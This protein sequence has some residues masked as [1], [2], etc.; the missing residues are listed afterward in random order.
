MR[1]KGFGI[2]VGLVFSLQTLAQ[3]IQI[4]DKNQSPI[5]DVFIYHDKRSYTAFTDA[6]G[7]A[8]I[9][10]FPVTGYFHFQHPA[11]EL[12]HIEAESLRSQNF[13]IA[14]EEK[15]VWFNELVISASKWE[16][17]EKDLAQQVMSVDRK[18]VEFNNPAT[19][20]DM[21]SQSGQVF[22]QKSQLGG[23][24]PKIR[25]FSAN[26]V[27]L[28]VD[29]VRM[30]NAIYRGGN[31]QNIINIDPN[32]ISSSE[33]VFGPGSVIYGSDA[34][35]GV[36]DFHTVAPR[37]N[38]N[39]TDVK[40]NL[41]TRYSSAA[42]ERTFHG[43]VAVA[44]RKFTYFGSATRTWMDDLRAGKN[45]NVHYNGYF[46]RPNYAKDQNGE[47]VIVTNSDPNVQ[48]GSGYD[49]TNVVQKFKFLLNQHSDLSYNFYFSTTS[50]IPRYDNLVQPLRD[51]SDS[52]LFVDW[53]Y[54]PQQWKMHMLQF[55]HYDKRRLLDQI[56]ITAAYQNYKESRNSRLFGTSIL[57][58]NEE[59]V[60]IFSLNVDL[61]KEIAK[62]NLFYGFEILYNDVASTAGNLDTENGSTTSAPSRYPD[63][64]SGYF[65]SALYLNR[66]RR[67]SEKWAVNIGARLNHVTVTGST[68]DP[69]AVSLGLE[70]IDIQNTSA[71]G[72]IGLI[73]LP[74]ESS[75]ISLT[76][77]TGFRSPNIDDAGK[78]F[79]LDNSDGIIVV[80]N[81]DIKP[82][83]SYNS[84][85]SYSQKFESITFN[86][87]GFY[88]VA[89]NPIIRDD[90]EV[91]GSSTVNLNGQD[92]EVRAQVNGEQAIIYG[93]SLQ[94]KA[95]ISDQ[96]TAS[97]SMN[98]MDGYETATNEPLRHTSPLFGRVGIKWSLEKW[99]LDAYSEFNGNRWRSEIPA[100]EIVDKPS[101]YT[102][103]GSPGWITINVK[104][105]I[106][107]TKNLRANL[108]IE[109]ILDTHYRPYSSGIS[110]PG[111][112]FIIGL[113]GSF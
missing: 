16:Q 34:L 72:M 43:D 73:H 40:T 111:R 98:I 75:K 44:R 39:G 79:E 74:N 77:S 106:H 92:M 53:H 5:S 58:Q 19:S 71:N 112:N 21:L 100:T 63:G 8:D 29:G 90:F 17:E 31:L 99:S 38:Q 36:M 6:D 85:L 13:S 107:L 95:N 22:V 28:V 76:L 96:V 41:L 15:K 97:G 109:N 78:I 7:K 113:R 27:L 45:R 26:A 108:G 83:Y 82:E 47:D 60:D 12:T 88:S 91:N 62:G 4:S 10:H 9:S 64:G 30:N 102:A 84:E 2:L 35:G 18:T 65:S 33:V 23:G 24:S 50:N 55:N 68:S 61:D 70:Q 59:N 42:N 86:L 20:A 48:V 81:N 87:V 51:G 25:G 105:S 3:T 49:L 66:V 57:E 93:G 67:F 1:T 94:F 14:L 110:A 104:S 52:L 80:P 69:A 32:A 56:R 37:W 46:L 11:F 101:L 103:D 54:G 89:S